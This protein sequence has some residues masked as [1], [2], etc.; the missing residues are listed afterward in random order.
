[1]FGM[2]GLILEWEEPVDL[3]FPFSS[4]QSF[5]EAASLMSQVS[6]QHLVLLHGVCMAGD[7]E[8][9]PSPRPR[10]FLTETL[11]GSISDTD[12]EPALAG[13]LCPPGSITLDLC[14]SLVTLGEAALGFH[15]Y[16][17]PQND[18]KSDKPGFRSHLTV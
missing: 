17:V 16:P 14:P 12:P 15:Q 11:Y 2:L 1:M 8:R 3:F 9:L 4:L 5:L 7:S 18:L 6:Y 10:P 13:A